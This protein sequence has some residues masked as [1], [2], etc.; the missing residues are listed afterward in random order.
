MT[1]SA[2]INIDNVTFAYNGIPVLHRVNLRVVD[3]DFAWIVGPNGGGKT[4][5]LK[6][7][8]G[9]LQPSEGS[10]TVL[11]K[12]PHAVRQTIGYMPQ[13]VSLDPQ[14]PVTVLDVVLMGLLGNFHP[15]GRV[16]R[17]DRTHALEALSEVGLA[18]SAERQFAH[19]SGGQQRRILIARALAARP[20][21]LLLDEPT[22]NLDLRIEQ[23]VFE[24]LQRLNE[25]L[26]IVMVSHDPAFVSPFVKSVV[27]VK[28]HVHVH[29]TAAIDSEIMSELYGR[30]I[31]MVRHDQQFH[32]GSQ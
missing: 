3:R 12:P 17:A 15:V 9:L 26:T 4:T 10:V 16:S 7:M 13:H 22:A 18:D 27:C 24:L 31:R 19:L 1:D 8:I 6:L 5:L 23:E 28:G 2:V 30:P 20:R 29:P 32:G 21:L 11:G 25:K 14:F